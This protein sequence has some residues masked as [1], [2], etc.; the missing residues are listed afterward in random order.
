MR[1]EQSNCCP[2]GGKLNT[3]GELA[4]ALVELLLNNKTEGPPGLRALAH[5]RACTPEQSLH[6]VR[7]SSV[8]CASLLCWG[9]CNFNSMDA[10]RSGE[11]FLVVQCLHGPRCSYLPQPHLYSVGCM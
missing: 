8:L 6:H 4:G 11:S 5:L 1:T 7:V 3:G 2:T 10:C 9:P